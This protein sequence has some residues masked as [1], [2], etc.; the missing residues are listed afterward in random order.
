MLGYDVGDSGSDVLA[1]LGHLDDYLQTV[2]T[3]PRDALDFW[4]MTPT[5]QLRN[6]K[7]HLVVLQPDVSGTGRS[8]RAW[9]GE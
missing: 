7:S 6:L 1:K 5:T 4:Q 8:S 3:K 2:T 9:F